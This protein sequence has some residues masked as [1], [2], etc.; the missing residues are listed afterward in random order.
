MGDHE[1]AIH[2]G[3][4]SKVSAQTTVLI[5]DCVRTEQR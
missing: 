5:V 3:L 2:G 4:Q 1:T